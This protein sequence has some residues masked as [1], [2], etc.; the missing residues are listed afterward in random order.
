MEENLR[1]PHNFQTAAEDDPR[2]CQAATRIQGQQCKNLAV[3]GSQYCQAH[4][5]Q[6]AIKRAEKA[7][8]FNYRLT[9]FRARV[10]DLATNPAIKSLRE[11]I[12]VLRMVL[13]ETINRCADE[14][15]LMLASTKISNLIASIER[16]VSSCHKLEI[17]LGQLLDRNKA[18]HLADE[19]IQIITSEIQDEEAIKRIAVGVTS[20]MSRISLNE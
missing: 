6:A 15:D 13:E 5:G 10:E 17:N 18:M 8:L 2:R 20:A 7:K 14:H 16:L 12:G 11:E 19:M 9:K 1:N 4:G 3:E